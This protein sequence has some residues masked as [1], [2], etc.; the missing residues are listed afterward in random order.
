[1][2]CFQKRKKQEYGLPGWTNIINS[3]SN[4][5]IQT[6]VYLEYLKKYEIQEN[7]IVITFIIQTQ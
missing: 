6:H 5:N 3:N 4:I 1:M 2:Y 7:I